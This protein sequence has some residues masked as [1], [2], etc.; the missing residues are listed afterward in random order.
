VIS[1]LQYGQRPGEKGLVFMDSGRNEL[2]TGMAAAGAN[3]I[4]S[5]P[6][7]GHRGFPFVPVIKVTGNEVMEGRD[8]GPINLG[9]WMARSLKSS[10]PAGIR[11]NNEAASGGETKAEVSATFKPWISMSRAVICVRVFAS[12]NDPT[13]KGGFQCK[14]IPELSSFS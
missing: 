11:K 2:L 10:R 7:A 8:H 6:V 14:K 9:S 5:L 12:T 4:V 13:G 3:V 1:G